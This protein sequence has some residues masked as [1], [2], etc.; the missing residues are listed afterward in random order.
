MNEW[1]NLTRHSAISAQTKAF[2]PSASQSEIGLL[3]RL[4][5]RITHPQSNSYCARRAFWRSAIWLAGC[6]RRLTRTAAGNR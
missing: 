5:W 4:N 2:T 6:R 1:Q 3:L